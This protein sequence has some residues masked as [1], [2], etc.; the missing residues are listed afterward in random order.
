MLDRLVPI[1]HF[2]QQFSNPQLQQTVLVG[3]SH[4]HLHDVGSEGED[5]AEGEGFE[6][7]AVELGEE[8]AGK[9]VG[10]GEG[11]GDGGGEGQ[12]VGEVALV[13]LQQ[14]EFELPEGQTQ[15]LLG[16]A[17][18]VHEVFV[19]GDVHEVLHVLPDEL[20]G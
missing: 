8:D 10:G 1:T 18:P 5:F 16:V 19:E 11:L 20:G 9:G 3:C 7:F 13:V 15:E 14:T 2:P 6:V 17:T 4:A 12:E